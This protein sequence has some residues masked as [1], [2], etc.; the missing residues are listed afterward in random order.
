MNKFTI[1]LALGAGLALNLATPTVQASPVQDLQPT[2]LTAAQFN[3]D[4]TPISGV[5][6]LNNPFSFLNSSGTGSISPA[7]TVESQVFQGQGAAAGLYAYTYQIDVN[8]V[9]DS[10][11]Q[12]IGVNST[13][14][15]FNATPTLPPTSLVAGTAPSSVY[16]VNAAIGGLN[17]PTTTGGS[18]VGPSQ[19]IWQPGTTTGSLTFQ[20]LDSTSNTG[21]LAAGTDSGTI[22]VLSTQAPA[23]SQLLV[24]LQ[25]PDP[26][27][28]YPQV[29]TPQAGTINPV[30]APEPATLI[31]WVGMIGAAAI[32]HRIRRNRRAA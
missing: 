3:S 12:P 26:Q 21:P 32:A 7:G 27:N 28:G 29:Y 2:S 22:V 23:S 11:G 31:G 1:A 24:S 6:A 30:P 15:Y 25:S 5:A 17:A 9:N 19:I 20:Y 14:M 8:N 13:A 10:T 16:L 18:V 4:F